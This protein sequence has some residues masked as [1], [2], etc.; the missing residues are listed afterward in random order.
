MKGVIY[1]KNYYVKIYDCAY[2][3][4]FK[5]SKCIGFVYYDKGCYLFEEIVEII[6]KQ[7]RYSYTK[8]RVIIGK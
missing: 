2:N 5:D 4:C 8:H 7:D 1:S 3:Y 6:P